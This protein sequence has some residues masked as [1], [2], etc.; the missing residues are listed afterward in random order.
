MMTFHIFLF[1]F[2]AI[3]FL[4]LLLVI[5]RLFHILCHILNSR[6]R[7]LFHR[8]CRLRLH[9]TRRTLGI[10]QRRIDFR[11]VRFQKILQKAIVQKLR[12]PRLGQHGPGQKGDLKRV[13]KGDPVKEEIG[14]HLDYREEGVD[15]PVNE[16]LRHLARHP[17]FEGL[18]ALE[19]G[20]DEADDAGD[21]SGADSEE[22]HYEEEGGASRGEVFL[23][24]IGLI[25][26]LLIIVCLESE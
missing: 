7:R 17:V 20:V 9:L 10:F 3:F 2:C 13:V 15:H 18:E 8:L 11:L 26:F 5:P 16:P 24:H 21:G 22:D 4:F 25:L 6:L 12:P 19:G 14:K 1:E 23:W